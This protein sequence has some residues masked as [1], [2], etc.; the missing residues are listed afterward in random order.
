MPSRSARTPTGQRRLG[1]GFR[2]R[3]VLV[4]RRARTTDRRAAITSIDPSSAWPRRRPARATGSSRPT[5]ASSRSATPASTDPPAPSAST[6]RSSAM[7]ATPTGQGYWFVASDGGIFTFGDAHFYGSTGGAPPPAPIT[8]MATIPNGRGY[9]LTTSAGQVY[10]FGDATFAGNIGPTARP[11]HR[12]RRGTRR[13]PARRQ[14]RE[15]VP[16]RHPARPAP[17]GEHDAAGCRGIGRVRPE[18]PTTFAGRRAMCASNTPTMPAIDVLPSTA[19]AGHSA[20]GSTSPTA[21]VP[22]AGIRQS[23]RS[24]CRRPWS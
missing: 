10:A 9:W 4:R 6:S 18:A 12:D 15:R 13:L 1:R 16:P 22:A 17:P 19:A 8:G 11:L 3:R 14:P 2:R 21:R 7:A 24:S 5:A 20:G 23:T